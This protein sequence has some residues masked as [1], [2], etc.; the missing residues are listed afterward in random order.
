MAGRAITVVFFGRIEQKRRSRDWWG[1]FF[2]RQSDSSW[3]CDV[4]PTSGAPTKNTQIFHPHWFTRVFTRYL[5]IATSVIVTSHPPKYLT[6]SKANGWLADKPKEDH[7][8]GARVVVGGGVMAVKE[9]RVGGG[10]ELER[11]RGGVRG[12]RHNRDVTFPPFSL[13]LP[14]P[15]L[16]TFLP[17]CLPSALWSCSH[18]AL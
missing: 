3:T 2:V 4:Q 16:P 13:S 8:N 11:E 15:S 10:R 17:A 14:L 1:V 9:V 18:A 5:R 6:Q 12:S 7:S